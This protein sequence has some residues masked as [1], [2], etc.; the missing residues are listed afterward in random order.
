[1]LPG[2]NT[3]FTRYSQQQRVIPAAVIEDVTRQA[4]YGRSQQ[5]PVDQIE[6][7]QYPPGAAI[8]IQKRV[9]R[10]KLVVQHGHAHQR[11]DFASALAITFFGVAKAFPVSQLFPQQRLALR[12]RVNC[13]L[14]AGI[15][16]G[17]ARHF[18]HLHFH[19][20]GFAANLLDQSSGQRA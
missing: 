20:F 4:K 6:Q 3:A 17:R 16:Q 11:V 15:D 18:A 8:A 14:R 9:N 13:L 12:W 10:L 7:H 5:P 2:F 1:M 19:A